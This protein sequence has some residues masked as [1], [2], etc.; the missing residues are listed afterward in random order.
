M[1]IKKCFLAMR[2]LGGSKLAGYDAA[3][4]SVRMCGFAC[5][6]A[7]GFASVRVHVREGKVL[8]LA[9]IRVIE[10]FRI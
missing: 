10:G 9:L 8:G 3:S 5:G 7:R 6:F 1:P 2:A 4:I